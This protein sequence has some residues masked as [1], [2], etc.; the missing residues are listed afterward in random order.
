MDK[1]I[2]GSVAVAIIIL[3]GV[4]W[5]NSGNQKSEQNSKEE[6]STSQ[7]AAQEKSQ[8]EIIYFYGDGCPHCSDVLEFIAANDIENK[9]DFTKKEVW[10]NAQNNKELSEVAKRCGLDPRD[11]GVPFVSAGGRCYIGGPSVKNFFKGKAGI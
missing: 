5:W 10:K 4:I 9:V 1:K 6:K 11:I 8:E 2:L 7:V 3:G